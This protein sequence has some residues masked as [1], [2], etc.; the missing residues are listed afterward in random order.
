MATYK[1]SV[2]EYDDVRSA[3]LFNHDAGMQKGRAE[4]LQEGR[5]EMITRGLQKGVSIEL[6]AEMSGLSSEYIM[7]NIVMKNK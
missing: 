4:G 1:K 7:M 2:L 6:L 5:E 3:M